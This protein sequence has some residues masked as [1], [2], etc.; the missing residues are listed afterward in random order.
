VEEVG[1]DRIAIGMRTDGAQA[2]VASEV[3]RE[4]V[5]RSS[6]S[7][8]DAERGEGSMRAIAAERGYGDQ[9]GLAFVFGD[10]AAGGE[11]GLSFCSLPFFR[12]PA[13]GHES[14]DGVFKGSLF[15]LI[16]FLFGIDV[17]GGLDIGRGGEF[18]RR[19]LR[20]V[21]GIV[22]LVFLRAGWKCFCAGILKVFV[23]ARL[24]DC[25]EGLRVFGLARLKV[26]YLARFKVFYWARWK[27][28]WMCGL[29]RSDWDGG[30]GEFADCYFAS[31]V[32]KGILGSPGLAFGW[33]VADCVSHKTH[34]P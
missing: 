21:C 13:G 7:D 12:G 11:F 15:A 14:L 27:R 30:W 5:R 17:L 34:R 26:F 1:L 3:G 4:S 2:G 22:H 20:S 28:D 8:G 25:F 29:W 32:G 31:R 24:K 33:A 6:A 10:G 18:S 23:L 19:I 16:L 9:R